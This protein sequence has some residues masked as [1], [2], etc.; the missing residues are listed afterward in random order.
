MND[1]KIISAQRDAYRRNFLVHGDTP[2]GTFQN[3]RLTQY[4]RFTHLLKEIAPHF[5][6]GTTIH[7]IG[8][9]LCDF[10]EYITD[11]GSFPGVVYSGTEIVEEMNV[12]A[13]EKFP[14]IALYN[15][16]FLDAAPDE[17]Y[18]FCVLSGTFNLLGSVKEDDWRE[19]CFDLV[20]KM[21]RQARK[22]ISFNF[23]TSYR[24]FS[25]PTLCYFDPR[26][27][28]DFATTKLSRF[29]CVNSTVPLY[30]VT[31]TVFTK[32]FV[33]SLYPQPE[34]GRYFK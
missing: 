27:M 3:D 9:G 7:D 19:M 34:L 12:A 14:D 22:A 10:Y 23:L 15:R 1:A 24:T 18:D 16:N 31:V 33:Q 5:E 11:E 30:E 2:K 4:V 6:A 32:E 21:F 17:M 26:E 25:D 20:E 8:S 29:V 28:M 13:R